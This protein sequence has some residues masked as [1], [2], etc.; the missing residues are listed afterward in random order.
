MANT[1]SELS[2]AS[3]PDESMSFEQPLSERMRTFLRIEF[4]YEQALY[5]AG[6]LTGFSARAA[7]ASLLEIAAKSSKSWSVMRVYL[8]AIRDSATSISAESRRCSVMS[9]D[10]VR[11]LGRSGLSL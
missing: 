4:L 10:S 11:S 2:P 3:S 6:D 8:P 1:A 7:I 5:H 9:K